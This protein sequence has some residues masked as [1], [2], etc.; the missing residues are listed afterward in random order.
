MNIIYQRLIIALLI[1]IGGWLVFQFPVPVIQIGDATL[2]VEVADT[3][4]K[5]ARG[6]SGRPAL[7]EN[8]GMLFVF[9]EPGRY[10]FWMKDMNFSIDIIWIGQDK[11]VVEIM[12][13]IA[14]ETFPEV[15]YSKELIQYVVETRAGFAKENNVQLGDKVSGL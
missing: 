12:N 1:L 3:D 15:F 13:T 10:G 9:E 5:R 8:E 4:Q 6:L 2:R 11:K 7:A 14:P